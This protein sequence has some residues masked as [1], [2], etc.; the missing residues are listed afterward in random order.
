MVPLLFLLFLIKTFRPIFSV[1]EISNESIFGSLEIFEDPFLN[2]KTRT[3][4]SACLTE[5]FLSIIY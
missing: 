5:R 2:L 4:L 3:R 1:T